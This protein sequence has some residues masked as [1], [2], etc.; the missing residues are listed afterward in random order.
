M[1]SKLFWGRAAGVLALTTIATGA[2]ELPAEANLIG[3][4][5]QTNKATPVYETRGSAN[6][7][8]TA[9]FP[10][11][12]K[13]TLSDNGSAGLIAIS[14][15]RSGFI[16]A[17][18]LKL[19]VGGP[20]PAPNP[21]PVPAPPTGSKCRKVLNPPEGLVIRQTASTSSSVVGGVAVNSQV[22]LSTD[23]ATLK[24]AGG[25]NWIEIST[26]AQGWIS[27]GLVGSR[28]NLVYCR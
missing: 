2:I 7:V 18:N 15:P 12:T 6:P 20:G 24:V 1:K 8:P 28:G 17:A 4:C 26:P 14:A 16:P 10:V 25:R 27:N 19:C 22:Q 11:D 13:V 21:T 3:Q 9:T 23:P 5:R